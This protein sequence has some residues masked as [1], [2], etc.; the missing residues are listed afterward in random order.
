MGTSR[1]DRLSEVGNRDYQESRALRIV[2]DLAKDCPG[3]VSVS[4]RGCVSEVIYQV[5]V[6]LCNQQPVSVGLRRATLILCRSRRG[7]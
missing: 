4:L 7:R 5:T 6:Q 2:A 3:V 1:C